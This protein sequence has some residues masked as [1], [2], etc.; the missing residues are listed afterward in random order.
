MPNNA[1]SWAMWRVKVFD[2]VHVTISIKGGDDPKEFQTPALIE[3]QAQVVKEI[4]KALETISRR[5]YRVAP[6]VGEKK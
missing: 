3:E 4:T 5:H 6:P 1:Y 2:R